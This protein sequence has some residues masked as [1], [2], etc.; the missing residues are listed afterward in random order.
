MKKG[1]LSKK[2]FSWYKSLVISED[3]II[4]LIDIRININWAVVVAR[5][6]GG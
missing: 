3:L 5:K 1:I 2:L 6:K 4:I